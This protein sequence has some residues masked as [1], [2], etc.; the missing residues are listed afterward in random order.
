MT[1]RKPPLTVAQLHNMLSVMIEAGKG[2]DTVVVSRETL[3]TD[4]GPQPTIDITDAHVG[5]DWNQGHVFLETATTVAAAG[6]EHRA[7]QI[8][9][10]QLQNDMSWVWTILR[11]DKLDADKKVARLALVLQRRRKAAAT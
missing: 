6:E 5:F 9:V 3:A 2:C 7:E 8:A 10:R 4:I 1:T 11:D